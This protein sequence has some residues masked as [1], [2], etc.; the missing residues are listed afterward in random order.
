M[1]VDVILKILNYFGYKDMSVHGNEIRCAKPDGNNASTIRIKI[2][3]EGKVYATDFSS[4]Y[5]GDIYGL[6]AKNTNLSYGQVKVIINAMQNKQEEIKKQEKQVFGGFFEEEIHHNKNTELITYDKSVLDDYGKCWNLRFWKDNILPSTQ[7]EFGLGYS[8]EDKRITI[9][10]YNTNGEVLGVMGRLNTDE[11]TN[12]KY[13]P[14]IPFPKQFGLYGL[15]QNKEN[16]RNSRVMIFESEK[17]VLQCHGYGYK[18]C[19]AL[20]GNSISTY[21]IN[22]LLKLNVSEFIFCFDEGLDVEVMKKAMAKVRDN[23]V[24]RDDVKVGIMFDSKNLY[25]PS[26]S[27]CSPSDLGKE[28]FELM[29]ENCIRLK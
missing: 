17:S 10:W 24:M 27:K 1:N 14:L 15:Y 4:A 8:N 3:D 18:N 29:V 12:Y 23:L 21:Q 25:L 7:L 11:Q 2:T 13:L 28:T 20:G 22:E 5:N 26:G 9:P 16:I 19:V 6:V